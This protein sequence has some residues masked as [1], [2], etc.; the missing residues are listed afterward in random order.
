MD[1]SVLIP[2]YVCIP[3]KILV[4]PNMDDVWLTVM[5]SAMDPRSDVTATESKGATSV[6]EADLLSTEGLW[7]TTTSSSIGQMR[8]DIMATKV[9][10]K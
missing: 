4:M 1:L 8:A 9:M 3:Q 5:H 2:M 10:K 7:R 6:P